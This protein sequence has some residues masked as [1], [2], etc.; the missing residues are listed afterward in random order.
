VDHAKKL[1][2]VIGPE[3]YGATAFRSPFHTGATGFEGLL[4]GRL[5]GT[6]ESGG[7]LR[8][9]LGAGAGLDPHFGAPEWRVLVGV[10]LFDRGA[11]KSI[12]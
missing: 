4:G 1:A 2:L 3:F 8:L 6:A 12:R 11:G 10:E 5:E 7:Q 9:R